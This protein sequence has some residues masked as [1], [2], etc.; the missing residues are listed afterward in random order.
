MNMAV[1]F[2]DQGKTLGEYANIFKRRKR[3]MIILAVIIFG[4]ALLTALLWP[5]TYQSSATILIEEQQ[6]PRDLVASTV[7]SYAAQQIEVIKARTMTM[8]NI[9]GLVNQHGLYDEDELSA[10]ARSEVVAEFIEDV[11]LD[12][13]SAGVIDPLT[14]RPTEA[15]IAFTL[16]YKHSSPNKAQKVASELV[17]LFLNENLRDRTEKSSSTSS[18]LKEEAESLSLKLAQLETEL[19]EFKLSNEGSLP[20]LYQYNLQV[21][22]RTEREML[23]VSLRLKELQKRQLQIE[24]ELVQLS[25][26][27]ATV[28]PD[29]R[30]VLSDYDRLKAIKS[31]YRQKVAV[32]NEQHPDV[33]RLK[34]EISVLEDVL[35]VT[36]SPEEYEQQL[37]MESDRLSL[38][39]DKYT[40]D[41][42]KVIA[43][44]RVLDKLAEEGSPENSTTNIKKDNPDNPAYVLM[45]TQ[46]KSTV[47]EIQVL[48]ENQLELEK[49]LKKYEDNILKAPMVE[50]NYIAMQRDYQNASLKYQEIKAKE[51]A[52]ELGQNLEQ[53]RK[54]ERFTLIDPPALPEEPVSP[55][56]P[57]IIFLGLIL[58]IGISVGFVVILE[59]MTPVIRGRTQLAQLA[60]AQPLVVVPYLTID[61]E[62]SATTNNKY[63]WIVAVVV[64]VI[65]AL[66]LVHFLV[67]PLDVTWFLILRKLGMS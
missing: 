4:I 67:K 64:G 9:M 26:Y 56:R 35:G 19:A 29:G 57:A 45:D 3:P 58:S 39:M 36:L 17:T 1:E 47:V 43:Q 23:D 59:A 44:K 54:G 51:M 21:I 6:I 38:L 30:S 34:R 31:D 55:N 42:P 32:Y 10:M 14:G 13:L 25:P 7:T 20:E 41:H 15:T 52:A 18:F 12:V 24:A 62:I 27:A 22:E 60:G 49:K 40:E 53:G 65:V 46:L 33:I 48:K 2:E 11:S 63:K 66:L 5:P 61:E 37:R 16:S 28:M 8:Q 50:K